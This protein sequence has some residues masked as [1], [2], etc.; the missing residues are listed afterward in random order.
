MHKLAVVEEAKTLMTEAKDWGVWHWLTEKRRVRAAAD[1]ANEALGELEKEVKAGWDDD[2]KKAYREREAQASVNGNSRARRQYEK[3]KE[4]ASH[5]DPEIKLAV[6]RVMELD[7]TAEQT[8]LDAE[9]TFDEAERRMS[10]GMAREGAQKA[11][12]AWVLREKAI[13]KAEAV[14]KK[15]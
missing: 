13:R 11:I 15:K 4:E 10:A 9:A 1:Q 14:G 8:R 7:D 3:A 2:L 5:V 6:E 12:D